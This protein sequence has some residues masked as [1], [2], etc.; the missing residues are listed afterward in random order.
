[1]PDDAPNRP[2]LPNH[3]PHDD[4][5]DENKGAAFKRL[6]DKLRQ[7]L[8]EC[9]TGHDGVLDTKEEDQQKI[10]EDGSSD[11]TDGA[12]IDRFGNSEVAEKSYHVYH[13][14]HKASVRDNSVDE[15][16][17]SLHICSFRYA[18]VIRPRLNFNVRDFV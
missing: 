15:S 3:H 8:L 12:G 18:F 16:Q 17:Y 9:R 7:P 1:M 14:G 2:P 5:R 11:R 6:R 13:P 4:I 10:D